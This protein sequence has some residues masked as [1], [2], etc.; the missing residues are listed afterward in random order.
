MKILLI[1]PPL[2]RFMGYYNRYF[3]ISLSCLAAV[4]QKEGHD[5]LIYDADCNINPTKMDF[6][7]LEDDY[8]DYLR[9]VKNDNHPIWQEMRKK[10]NDF[11]PDIVGITVWTTFVASAFK[12]ASLCKEYNKSLPVIM[13]GPHVTFNPDEALEYCD[14]VVIGEAEEVWEDLIKDYEKGCLK[15]KYVGHPL[16]DFYKYYHQE[17]LSSP[18]YVIQD[19]LETTRGC[20]FNC[21]FCSIPPLTGRLL[22]HKPIDEVIELI[23]KIRPCYK[24]IRFT[25]NNIYADP[26]YSKE[27][28]RR[29]IPLKIRWAGACST[30]IAKDEE[31]LQLAKQSG[32]YWLMIGYEISPESSEKL[33]GGKFSLASEYVQLAKKI[34]KA[35]I[36]IRANGIIGFDSDSFKSLFNMWKFSFKIVP[37]MIG[38]SVLAPFPGTKLYFRLLKENR[39]LNLNWR[40]YDARVLVFK[41][42][43]WKKSLTH[44][45]PSFL[46][47]TYFTTSIHG[48]LIVFILI[49]YAFSK[50]R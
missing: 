42:K 8:P 17:L 26:L 41:H 40:E 29:L 36:R 37:Y 6:T 47:F 7:Q 18:P 45:Y 4:L 15:K 10:T 21:E 19:F 50:W 13:G 9:S 24:T 23:E 11:K 31:A 35:G 22:R 48:R 27:L 34:K 46:M 39:I 49:F 43:F 12:V 28:F 16:A 32:C 25:D 20:K 33:K 44:F 38:F 30:D 5:V 2:F 14:S 3:P 1:D